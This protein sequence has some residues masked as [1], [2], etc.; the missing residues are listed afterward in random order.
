[1][2]TRKDF[3]RKVTAGVSFGAFLVGYRETI[4]RVF[5]GWWPEE[6]A[7]HPIYHRA[8]PTE[9]KILPSGEIK[10]N[11]DVRISHTVCHGCVTLCGMRVVQDAKSGKV[12][13]ALGNPY[14][15]LSADPYLPYKTSIRESY[16]AFS[17][18]GYQYRGTAC[19]RG[20]SAIEKMK[21][22]GRVTTV[23]K[24][25][26][27]R[28]SGK[29][30]SIPF[31][32]AIKEI[33][34]GGK[35][36]SHL[37]EDRHIEGLKQIRDTK[38]PIDPK[39][40][41]F[42]PKSNQLLLITAFADGRENIIRRFF[43]AFGTKNYTGHRG[44]CGLTMRAANAALLNDWEKH[45][46]LK[47]DYLHNEFTIFIGT[48]PAGNAGNPFKRQGKLIA[49]ARSEGRFKYVVV[50]PV[51]HSSDN[52]PS[53]RSNWI[54]IQPGTDA[55]LAMGMARWIFENKR[56]DEKFLS[57]PNLKAA[58]KEEEASFSG[59]TWLVI[60]EKGHAKE[61]ALLRQSDMRGGP[62]EDV[63]MVM[64]KNT[65][66]LTPNTLAGS[67]DLF[68][69]GKITVGGKPVSVKTTLVQYREQAMKYSLDEYAEFCGIPKETI[70]GLA[71]EFTSH[72][73][74]AAVSV[75]GGTMHTAGFYAAYSAMALNGLI[76]NLNWK[77][78]THVNG[79]RFKDVK[80]GPKYNLLKIAGA[81]KL[82]GIKLS[83]EGAPYQ[84]SSEFKQNGYP[85]RVPWYTWGKG[86]QAHYFTSA[87]SG[88][89]Y[90]IKAIINWNGNPMRGVAS[91]HPQA[92]AM[93]KDPG[94]VP[95]IVNID[96]F[97]NETAMF[98][99]Y[100]FPDS[101]MYEMWG[102]SSA[103]NGVP[104][105]VSSTRYPV[106]DM[107]FAKAPNGEQMDGDNTII[108]FAIALGLPGFGDKAIPGKGGKFYPLK[109][110]SD[111][112]L[113]AFANIAYDGKN[114]VPDASKEDMQLTGVDKFLTKY[115]GILT[116]E[117]RRKVAFLLTRGGRFQSYESSYKGEWISR[118]YTKPMMFYQESLATIPYSQTGKVHTA[119][120]AYEEL[121]Y[122]DGSTIESHY[123]VK[124]WPFRLVTYKSVILNSMYPA[125]TLMGI[126]PSN[127][128]ELH[129]DHARELGFRHG[130]SV[131]LETPSTKLRGTLRLREGIAKNTIAI[132]GGFGRSAYGAIPQF[133]N[134][135][136]LKVHPSIGNGLHYNPIIPPDPTIKIRPAS[137]PSD[138]VSGAAARQ[139]H[140]A[141]LV[142]G[143]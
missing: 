56:Y 29:W 108:Q 81:P 5:R 12:L 17:A 34:E 134:G 73:K 78:G 35:L 76:G 136:E 74:K 131:V 142:R 52:R 92:E 121:R 15:P 51:Q 49:Q 1:M 141:R 84:K 55:A 46:H 65:G 70:I 33:T 106:V 118:R 87:L 45:P 123:P 42:G 82:K 132:E 120:P 64:D 102:S 24:R 137:T 30:K 39:Q 119:T 91:V 9:A 143:A 37:G 27:A 10:I 53:G 66:R 125:S 115:K 107:P 77:G 19:A 109:K 58:E 3:L 32:Q 26:G 44:T 57:F 11:P 23:L 71:K 54:P 62:K 20:N 4:F 72:G 38:T 110:P 98:A 69:E 94:N 140:P 59:A 7:G 6:K 114:P 100:L 129:P 126:H 18:E 93:I 68:Y 85:A 67:A 63:F 40:K 13:R 105:K 90:K 116:T 96:P 36:F 48:S 112:Y 79:A 60:T 75:H 113:R 43:R 130:E 80:P 50:D 138:Y 122:A 47:P 103:W 101:V 8:L 99:D 104:G 61:G 86:Q 31:E 2:L 97:I 41:E 135:K 117:E 128:I 22:P 28:G 14:H 16:K 21:D 89:P 139:G 88:Y 127:F 133:V 111:Y 83:R 95:L 25:D 124:D